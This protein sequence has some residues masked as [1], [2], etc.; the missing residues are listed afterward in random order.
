MLDRP[1]DYN[2]VIDALAKRY[3]PEAF[4]LLDNA[5]EILQ[6]AGFYVGPP[7]DLTDD[8]YS[9][10]MIV[11]REDGHDSVDITVQM[12]EAAEYGD[13]PP[14]GVNFGLDI[15]EY[16]GRILGGLSPFNYTPECWV[17]G[18]DDAAVAER[19]QVLADADLSNLPGM[20]NA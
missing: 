6:G 8:H 14:Y 18:K 16:G 2:D 10:S 19:W 20:L 1:A 5:R 3:A 13:D 15:V 7:F 11:A 17:D 9:W 12:A 4:K